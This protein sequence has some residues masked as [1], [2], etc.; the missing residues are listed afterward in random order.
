[1]S[2]ADGLAPVVIRPRY[3]VT[4][5]RN[6]LNDPNG[7]I[8]HEGRYHLFYQHNPAAPTWAAPSWGHVSSADL[9][10][11]VDHAVALAPRPD[12]PDRD[13]C[14]SGCARVVDG[15]PVIFYTAVVES[16]GQRTEAVG[17]ARGSRDM[18]EWTQAP[19]ALIQGPPPEAMGGYHRDPFVFGTPGAWRMLI[20]SGFS[21]EAH[22][23]GAILHYAS[24]DLETW[25]YKGILYRREGG[26][27]PLDTGPLW[28]C[29]QLFHDAAADVLI[30]SVN[31]EDGSADA[32]RYCVYAVGRLVDDAFEADSLGRL[33]WGDVFYAPAITTDDGRAL[34]WGWVQ[35]KHGRL[36]VDHS[37]ALSLPRVVRLVDGRLRVS[38]AAEL[39]GLRQRVAWSGSLADGDAVALGA[40]AARPECLEIEATIPAATRTEV[41]LAR[42]GRAGYRL[43]VDEEAGRATVESG[44]SG[45]FT[46]PLERRG[47]HR[48]LRLFIDG[49]VREL[50][51][52]DEAAVT[53]RCYEAPA[54]QLVA[55]GSASGDV[56]RDV[57]VHEMADAMVSRAPR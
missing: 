37:G 22:D 18:L 31:M 50:F 46:V 45:P 1:M 44:A 49:S 19:R 15:A 41:T 17:V 39:V 28:E 27:A 38:P 7:V 36:D 40:L 57:V 13:G 8:R 6:W 48:R 12:G 23:S 24:P 32:L 5:P 4:A 33:D 54:E 9:A 35:E 55:S 53:T 3:H 29:P 47:E 16:G 43:V 10:H 11:W 25:A 56:L 21:G 30:F 20:G 42:G 34:M 51:I 14:W 52:D 2:L 26:R